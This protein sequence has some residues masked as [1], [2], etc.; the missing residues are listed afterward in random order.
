MQEFRGK[1]QH[2]DDFGQQMPTNGFRGGKRSPAF[3]RYSFHIWIVFTIEERSGHTP[4]LEFFF[5]AK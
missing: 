5:S 3:W 2:G 4:V 1:D